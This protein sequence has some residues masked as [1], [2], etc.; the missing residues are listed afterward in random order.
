LLLIDREPLRTRAF[1]LQPTD[2]IVQSLDLL[3]EVLDLIP[4]LRDA[5]ELF[6][7]ALRAPIP[8]H[9]ESAFEG[10]VRRGDCPT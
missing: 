6:P 7:F 8:A 10:I 5:R 4:E 2:L 9:R 1:L 3:S